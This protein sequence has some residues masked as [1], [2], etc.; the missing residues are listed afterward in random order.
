MREHIH[1]VTITII[2]FMIFLCGI[3]FSIVFLR[4]SKIPKIIE[5]LGR[6]TEEAKSIIYKTK[7]IPYDNEQDSF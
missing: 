7:K 5:A 4:F 1:F 3:S 2:Y 6:I